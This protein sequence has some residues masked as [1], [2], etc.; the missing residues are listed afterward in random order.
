MRISQILLTST[1]A[2]ASIAAVQ[3][4]SVIERQKP[5]DVGLERLLRSPTAYMGMRVRFTA[6]FV[7]TAALFDPFHTRFTPNEY[8]NI[9]VW[10]DE[11]NI[12]DPEVRAAP[13]TTCYFAKQREGAHVVSG[14]EKYTQIEIIGEVVSDFRNQA[15]IN[16]HKVRPLR[17]RGQMTDNSVYHVQQGVQLAS[18]GAYELADEHFQQALEADL[19]I[20]AK[21]AVLRIR[22]E[23]LL[24]AQRWEQADAVLTQALEVSP[25][26]SARLHYL[27]ARSLGE[28]ADEVQGD[29]AL[30]DTLFAA[31]VDHAQKAISIDPEL[32][33]AYA[34]LG[35]SLAGLERF[36][37]AK[38]QCERAIRLL[39]E[40]AEVRWYLG[41]ILNRQGDYDQA[42]AVL[43]EAIDRAPKDDRL[44]KSIARSYYQ[45]GLLGGPGAAQDIETALRED[46]IAIRLNPEDPDLPYHSGLVLET[47]TERGQQVR[48]GLKRADAT[49]DMAIERFEGTLAID[50]GYTEAH[51]RLGERY[52]AKEQHDK[53]VGHYQRALELEPE[54]DELYGLLGRYLWD[55]GQREEAY[56]VYLGHHERNPQYI[57]TVY[58]L[59][60]LSLELD[61][62]ERAVG[63]LDQVL[64]LAAEHAMAHADLTE[65]H[66]ELG[67]TRDAIEHGERALGLLQDEDQ[68]RRVNRFMGLAHWLQDES[69][70]VVAHLAEHVEGAEEAR[71][72]LALGWARSLDPEQADEVLAL[73]T[74]ALALDPE[75]PEAAELKGWGQYLSG[76]YPAAEQTLKPI[77]TA[78]PEN[79][80]LAYRLG[81][82][83]YQQGADRFDEA[84][85]LLDQG[86]GLRSRL[87]MLGDARGEIK[88]ARRAI[89]DH[90]RQVEREQRDAERKAAAEQ[91]EAQRQAAIK[92]REE[93]RRR[94]AGE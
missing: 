62:D 44:H 31:A 26:P 52:R 78:D 30:V 4:E 15:F 10:D 92:A 93:E 77:Y 14:L 43:K 64:D 63:W 8:M 66:L 40:N 33:D 13:V 83:V 84:D 73:G 50:E 80:V 25:E 1:L 11:A 29:E 71:L 42:I 41:R 3:A 45:R 16:I 94:R 53:A 9:V 55:L 54:R 27:K 35:I 32:G 22:G 70:E 34:V 47:A 56:A 76:N 46:D 91:R 5:H 90:R 2:M 23:N 36:D 38:R 82:A 17:D 86:Y 81:M 24:V 61:L 21:V 58:A 88:D 48:V 18:G 28:L 59:G 39:P 49:Y 6:T 74:V 89:R 68:L 69:E 37:E 19:P 20:D 57:D 87:E 75:N 7:Q 67:Q 85:E 72:P 12:W 65:S 60:R 51:V 79:D